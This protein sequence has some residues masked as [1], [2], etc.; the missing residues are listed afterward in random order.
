VLTQR[1]MIDSTHTPI[2][3]VESVATLIHI[4]VVHRNHGDGSV[5]TGTVLK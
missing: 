5:I 4:A 1:Q 3:Q 2:E